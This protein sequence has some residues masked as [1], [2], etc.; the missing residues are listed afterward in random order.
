MK[1]SQKLPPSGS[2]KD[3]FLEMKKK[4]P[5]GVQWIGTDPE[6]KPKGFIQR[7]IEK[8]LSK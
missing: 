4:S 7:Q 2:L 3:L 5:K 6:P 8:Y 1:N